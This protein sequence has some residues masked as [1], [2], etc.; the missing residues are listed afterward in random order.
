M[1]DQFLGPS[2]PKKPCC[3]HCHNATAMWF[4]LPEHDR[5]RDGKTEPCPGSGQIA[6]V[7]R[8]AA[9]TESTR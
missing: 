2:Y 1:P 7:T 6:S 9:E 5:V 8:R 3:P 4:I